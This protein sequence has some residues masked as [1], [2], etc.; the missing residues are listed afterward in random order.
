[1]HN[2]ENDWVGFSDNNRAVSRSIIKTVLNWRSKRKNA[3]GV[4]F[5]LSLLLL[6]SNQ[7]CLK[8][9]WFECNAENV[10]YRFLFEWGSTMA[11]KKWLWVTWELIRFRL[12]NKTK[13][14][15]KNKKRI[16][17]CVHNE[18]FVDFLCIR[19]ISP[20]ENGERKNAEWD[21]GSICQNSIEL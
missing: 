15:W 18:Y 12:Q 1:M 6:L 13:K 17:N 2:D 19:Q 9:L 16:R 20:P 3:T 5:F 10:A 7:K 14:I 4:S 21:K 11:H 8:L